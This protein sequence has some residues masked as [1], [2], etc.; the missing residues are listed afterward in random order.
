MPPL[1]G[2]I[3]LGANEVSSGA[4]HPLDEPSSQPGHLAPVAQVGLLI[5]TLLLLAIVLV[6]TSWAIRKPINGTGNMLK[7]LIS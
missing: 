1:G 6:L 3:H 5:G 7:A 4:D 2:R